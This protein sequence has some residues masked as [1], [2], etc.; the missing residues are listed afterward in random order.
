M[1][2]RELRVM[3][4]GGGTAGHINPGLAIAKEILK[5]R[6]AKIVFVGTEKGLEKELIPK[7]GFELKMINVRGF[8]RKFSL[9]TLLF[10][11]DLAKGHI[12]ARNLI[13]EFK[14]DIVIGTG[15][16]VCGP[17][18]LNASVMGIPTVIHEQNAYPGITNKILSRFVDAIMISFEESKEYFGVKKTFLT[19][20]PLRPEILNADRNEA[21]K[22]YKL[23]ESKL[24]VAFGGSRGAE[25]LNKIIANFI[26]DGVPDGIK[27]LFATGDKNF[28]KVKELLNDIKIDK[29]RVE[30]VP[31]IHNMH[32]VLAA[33]DLLISRAG[34]TTLSEVTALGIPSVLIP[35]PN[36]TN[37]HQEYN[38]R[39]L[40]KEG[41]AEVILENEL[42]EIYFKGYIT[43]LII[44]NKKLRE[45]SKNS[46]KLGKRDAVEKIY[47]VIE[48]CL[49]SDS[50]D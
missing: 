3:I 31:Y 8:K 27:L 46:K 5:R 40:Q 26:R 24:V 18:L 1:N 49:N 12:Q 45:M 15:G 42:D 32:E 10:V 44:D 36:V 29:N 28:A 6:K 11:K 17:V 9:D 48:K 22:K 2:G 21:R 23:G 43:N 39:A 16:Y 25:K 41:A 30:I 7:E 13:K 47:E 14:P 50:G 34:A 33:A 35:S 4:A 20:N 37:N 19:G 38:A